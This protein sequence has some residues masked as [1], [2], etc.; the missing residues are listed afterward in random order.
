MVLR[1]AKPF[2]WQ[3]MGLSDSYDDSVFQGAMLSLQNLVPDTGTKNVWQCRPA[4]QLAANFTGFDSPG[5][6]SGMLAVGNLL[7]GMLATSRTLG[8][9]EPFVYD[10]VTGLFATVSGVTSVN[11]PASP[12]SSGVWTPPTLVSIGGKVI[13][14]HPGFD[15]AAGYDFGVLDLNNPLAP[16]WSAGTLTGAVALPALPVAVAQFGGRCWYAV[17]NAV[18]FSDTTSPTNCTAGT[19]V[20]TFGSNQPVTALAGLPLTNTTTGGVVQALIVFIGTITMYQITGDAALS[21]L[22]SNNLN[23]ATGT[24][25][26]NSVC[27][28]PQG[29]AFVSPEGVRFINAVSQVSDPIGV[30]GTGVSRVFNYA[31][32]PTRVVM[33]YAEDVIRVSI[34]DSSSVVA[35]HNE[36]FYHLSGKRWS[37]PHTFPASLI[38]PVGNTFYMAPV[39]IPGTLWSSDARPNLTSGFIENGSQLGWGV[40]SPLLPGSTDMAMHAVAEQT[41]DVA[42]N[43]TDQY[44]FSF[45]DEQNNI[46]AK[47]LISGGIAASVWGAFLWGAALWGSAS[48]AFSTHQLNYPATVV[49]K[50]AYFVGSGPSSRAFRLGNIA[51]R[52]QELGYVLAP[53]ATLIIGKYVEKSGNFL[54]PNGVTSY[55]VTDGACTP[56]SNVI[57]LPQTADA[58]LQGV[59]AYAIAGNGSFIVYCAN[60]PSTDMQYNYLVVTP[61]GAT[62]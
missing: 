62:A 15:H 22:S 60:S 48:Q 43:Q 5:F 10:T 49:F 32:V 31:L 35:T 55:T 44:F 34:A 26:Q 57:L 50:R 14:T 17:Q 61:T 58:A 41:V 1:K 7:V 46:L 51:T 40:M 33:Q 20:L 16:V 59:F 36:Y 9:D 8:Y 28:T 37:G 3:P 47:A 25:N 30:Y 19:Q 53:T 42:L 12:P 27:G 52:V 56:G 13:I 45:L 4:A 38:Q 24:Y 18:V 23:V 21:T 2:N 29:L 6:V 11:V 39:G 54:L